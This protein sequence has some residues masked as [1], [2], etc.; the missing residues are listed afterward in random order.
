MKVA[1]AK[2]RL[3]RLIPDPEAADMCVDLGTIPVADDYVSAESAAEAFLRHH[4]NLRE[5]SAT[6]E[7][8]G[9]PISGCPVTR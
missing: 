1:Q 9:I 4:F 2:Y 8:D 6:G 5:G 3:H 7:I